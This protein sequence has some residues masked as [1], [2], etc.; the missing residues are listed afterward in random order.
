MSNNNIRNKIL[1]EPVSY[2]E[3][4]SIHGLRISGIYKIENTVNHKV[5]IGQSKDIIKRLNDHIKDEGNDHLRNSFEKYGLDKFSFEI[6]KE[7]Y[8]LNYW[9]IFLIQVYHAT[10]DRYGYNVAKGGGGGN[11]GD[12]WYQR[13]LDTLNTEEYHKSLR[14]AQ[15]Q[16]WKSEEERKKYSNICSN[17]W[18]N[19]E[20][21]EKRIKARLGHETKEETRRKIGKSNREK[22]LAKHLHWYNNGIESKQLPECP[23]GW[24]PGKVPG[25]SKGINSKPRTEEEKKHLSEFNKGFRIWNNGK[26]QIRSKTKPGDDFILGYLNKKRYHWFTNG[27]EEICC[28]ICPEGF[29]PGRLSN[30]KKN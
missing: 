14:Q 6:I 13:L 8:D 28:E 1:S 19:P 9:E 10:D 30:K 21:R 7:T 2:E 15:Q 20:I 25:C 27:K 12:K 16:R 26:I 18:S 24:K 17:Q 11:M 3:L 4:L 29:V 23:N 22:M 5:Y